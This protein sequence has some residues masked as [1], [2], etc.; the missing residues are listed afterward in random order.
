M[1]IGIPVG[2]ATGEYVGEAFQVQ[3]TT[4]TKG[5]WDRNIL[6]SSK[7]PKDANVASTY[8]HEKLLEE[9]Q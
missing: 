1:S 9:V 7:S 5:P 4:S 8:F 3:Y 2:L 6:A